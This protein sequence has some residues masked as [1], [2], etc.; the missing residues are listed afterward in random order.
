[1]GKKIENANRVGLFIWHLRVA[2]LSEGG[3]ENG[4]SEGKKSFLV[5]QKKYR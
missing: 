3:Q 4:F 5:H 1:V 2:T